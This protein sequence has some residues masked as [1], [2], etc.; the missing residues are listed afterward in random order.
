MYSIVHTHYSKCV[1]CYLSQGL[2]GGQWK[3]VV[4]SPLSP[5]LSLCLPQREPGQQSDS[6]PPVSCE[7]GEV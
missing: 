6:P 4:V 3:Q 2:G 5:P 1:V 7:V